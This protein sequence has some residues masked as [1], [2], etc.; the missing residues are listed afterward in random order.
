MTSIIIPA[1]NA[2]KYL[3]AA[4]DSVIS[5]SDSDWELILV[6]DGSTDST[7]GICDMAAS[8]DRRIRALHTANRGV[9]A[10][11]NAGLDAAGGDYIAFLDADDLFMPDFLKILAGE[12]ETSGA[13]IAAC[14]FTESFTG[15]YDPQATQS[16][17]MSGINALD[18]LFYQTPVAGSRHLLDTSIWNKVYRRKLWDDIR[19]SEGLRY[20][21]LDV[22]YRLLLTADKLVFVP[23]PLYYYR[24]HVGS[25]IHTYSPQRLDV[26]DVTDRIVETLRSN[27][28]CG[29]NGQDPELKAARTRRFAAH[30]NIYVLLLRNGSTDRESRRRCLRV[31]RAERKMVAF[32]SKARLKDRVGAWLAFL[33]F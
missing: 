8:T 33:L 30:C 23:E 9:S 17:I 13:D 19:F 14:P 11:R 3:Q 32:N 21:D 12:L 25:F 16:I 20:E 5:Q 1:H 28:E 18:F 27:P 24:Q 15:E 22:F 7:P 4:I 31:I 29:K 26:L 6:D 10:A 2:E